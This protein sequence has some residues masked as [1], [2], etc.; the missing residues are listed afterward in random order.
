MTTENE[1][2]AQTC[3]VCSTDIDADDVLMTVN[4]DVVCND[5]VRSCERCDD[6]Y[7]TD[8]DMSVVN[9]DSVWCA[10]CVSQ[11]AYYC[12]SCEEYNSYGAVRLQD[13]R[14]DWCEDCLSNTYWCEDCDGYYVDG[15]DEGHDDEP[16]E[17]IIHDYN[18]KP[19]ALFHG[20]KAERL[21]FGIE[22]EV[23]AYRNLSEASEYAYR[24]EQLGLAYLK[25]DGS[26]SNGFEVV[27]HPISHHYWKNEAQEFFDTMEGLR[28]EHK[29]KSWDTTT[30][31]I[32]IHVSRTGFGN[33]VT[34]EGSGP[35]MHRFLNLIYS[36]QELYEALAGRA[37]SRW[38]SFHDIDREVWNYDTDGNRRGTKSVRHIRNKITH[39]YASERYSAV[40]TKNAHTLEIRIFRGSVNSN[41][42]KAHLDLAHASVEYTRVMSV[43]QV[44]DGALSPDNFIAYIKANEVLY[45][46]LVARLAKV[47]KPTLVT[48]A[49]I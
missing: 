6:V 40:N 46:E 32:H 19:D 22:I 45:P 24:L 25:S 18:Y 30:C 28:T 49:T 1:V 26:L 12:D 39:G 33:A 47:W 3:A 16:D 20:T 42:I 9:G 29:V 41:V 23:E 35:H 36:N 10:D 13:R 21:Y 44:R 43:S 14:E 17:R 31:G 7:S 15:C 34:G 37:S 4:D 11:R 27:S 8:D 38:A 2:T 48:S 5:C